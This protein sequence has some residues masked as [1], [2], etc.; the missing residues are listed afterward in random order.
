MERITHDVRRQSPINAWTSTGAVID[1]FRKSE[2]KQRCVF[3][4]FDIVEFYPSISEEL[5]LWALQFARK[6]T[7]ISRQDQDTIL[8]ARKSLLFGL[9]RE[10]VKKG[11]GLFDVTMGWY[12]GAEVCELVGALALTK[13]VEEY[14]GGDIGLYRDDGLAVFRDVSGPEVDRIRKHIT[15]IFHSLGLKITIQ[16]NL[17]TVDFLDVTLD[18]TTVKYR[19]YRKPKDRPL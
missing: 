4:C 6:F 17:K 18:L 13:L 15:K 16:A 7:S 2:D 9:E 14:N 3:I 19:P 5:L 10:W 1:W 8:H 12:D 11:S